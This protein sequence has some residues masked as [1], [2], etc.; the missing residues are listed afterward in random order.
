MENH[1]V[2]MNWKTIFLWYPF[3]PKWSIY[4][5]QSQSTGCSQSLENRLKGSQRG[6]EESRRRSPAESW[7]YMWTRMAV[8]GVHVGKKGRSERYWKWD[9][10]EVV[11]EGSA[12][13]RRGR[14][15]G[16]HTPW[17]LL[18]QQCDQRCLSGARV[19]GG[20]TGQRAPPV[21]MTVCS[22]HQWPEAGVY[23]DGF[24]KGR[25]RNGCVLTGV[26]GPPLPSPW[27]V[28]TGG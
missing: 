19:S 5:T 10:Q 25:D 15:L 28:T 21:T 22:L 20:G 3:F 4:S 2:F 11:M 18:P 6:C 14:S 13:W 26:E 1:I 7:R 8:L 12:E 23:M 24:R 16:R 9:Q 27:K 17:I